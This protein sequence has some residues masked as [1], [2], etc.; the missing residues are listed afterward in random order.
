MIVVNI[1]LWNDII[2]YDG[3]WEKEWYGNT[4]PKLLLK[5]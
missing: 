4:I 3:T 5:I 2:T 1:R